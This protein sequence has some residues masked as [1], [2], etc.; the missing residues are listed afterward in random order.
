MS[1]EKTEF[2]CHVGPPKSQP[3]KLDFE[4]L[5]GEKVSER[6]GRGGKISIDSLENLTLSSKTS[7]NDSDQTTDSD[8][9]WMPNDSA[10]SKTPIFFT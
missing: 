2:Y 8:R 1:C 9:Q 7:N 5:R 3:R 6:K 10:G 4:K